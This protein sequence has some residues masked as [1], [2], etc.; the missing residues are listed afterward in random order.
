M[1]EK[2]VIETDRLILRPF[3]MDDAAAVLEFSSNPEVQRY[4]GDVLRTTLAEVEHVITNVWLSDYTKYGYGRF[5]VIHKTDN[6]L[7][8]FNGIKYL[9]DINETDLGYRF[10]PEYW[11]KG[12]ATES[13]KAIV[14]YAFS[15]HKLDKLIGFVMP[16]NQASAVVLKKLDFEFSKLA[17][18]P[19]EDEDGD[20][21][22]YYLTR[23]TYE[24]Q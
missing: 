1:M 13:S 24:R 2:L 22:W 19:G 11:N 8:G 7:I 21:E 5:A 18:Y 3:T 12:L 17:P 23:A 16:E 15:N 20:L 6:K 10:L 14:D 4:T 9:A